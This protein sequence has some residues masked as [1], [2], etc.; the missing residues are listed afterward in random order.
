MS[1]QERPSV[2]LDPISRLMLDMR[3]RASR[4]RKVVEPIVIVRP[5]KVRR[6]W[7]PLR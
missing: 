2:D 6:V 3:V 1:S 7:N 5:R 4:M